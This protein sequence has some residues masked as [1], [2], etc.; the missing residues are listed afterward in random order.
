MLMK[1][2]QVKGCF[3]KANTWKTFPEA[4][5]GERMLGDGRHVKVR[6]MKEC[7]Y[8]PHRQWET[9]PELRFSLLHFAILC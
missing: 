9:S 6:L 5:T 3:A 1:Q 2:T 7:N 4:D 8:D